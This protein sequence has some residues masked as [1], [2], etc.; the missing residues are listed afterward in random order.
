M[1]ERRAAPVEAGEREVL[2]GP[3]GPGWLLLPFGALL[4]LGE[5]PDP[6][7]RGVLVGLVGLLLGAWHLAT[8]HTV[9]DREG[10]R[11][12]GTFRHRIAWA[13]VAAVSQSRMA[14]HDRDVELTV[15][16]ADGPVRIR[17]RRGGRDFA[18]VRA[19]WLRHG[20]GAAVDQQT[21]ERA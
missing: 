11:L 16:G 2:R 7:L 3:V 13:D 5:L 4:L 19:W 1:A 10:V 20:S 21:G 14:L 17:E 8:R 6:T 12:P 15:R 9:L 18:A